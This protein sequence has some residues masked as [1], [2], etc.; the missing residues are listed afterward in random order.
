VV[1]HLPI[2]KPEAKVAPVFK[3]DRNQQTNETEIRKV[4]T[5]HAMTTEVLTNL[6]TALDSRFFNRYHPFKAF[7]NQQGI[8]RYYGANATITFE[9]STLADMRFSYIYETTLFLD[10]CSNAKQVIQK[11]CKMIKIA[12]SDFTKHVKTARFICG[13][14]GMKDIRDNAT[15]RIISI[16]LKRIKEMA[17]GY[18][19]DN[20]IN[21]IEHP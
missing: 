2:V 5:L 6:R 19:K 1:L 17:I 21:E 11:A 4:D 18:W 10:P 7:K 20:M 16:I 13:A 14:D 8:K 12:D 3:L 9:D 15:A